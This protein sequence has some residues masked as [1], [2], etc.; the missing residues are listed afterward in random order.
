MFSN[1]R[2]TKLTEVFGFLSMHPNL[3]QLI[4]L[5]FFVL[6]CLSLFN[7]A[8][9]SVTFNSLSITGTE[10][11]GASTSRNYATLFPLHVW[12]WAFFPLLLQAPLSHQQSPA[13]CFLVLYPCHALLGKGLDF[14]L[15]PQV[16]V[17]TKAPMCRPGCLHIASCPVFPWTSGMLILHS[18]QWSR[19]IRWVIYTTQIHLAF[20]SYC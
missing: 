3:W 19:S 12:P 11:V 15:I 1:V 13:H 2:I 7:W 6:C 14:Q 16:L 10:A 9:P 17:N 4:A 20:H 18:A 8:N 5:R